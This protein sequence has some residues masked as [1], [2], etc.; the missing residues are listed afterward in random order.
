[1]NCYQRA[2]VGLT[3]VEFLDDLVGVLGQV[4]P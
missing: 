4:G 2:R 1:M 3:F